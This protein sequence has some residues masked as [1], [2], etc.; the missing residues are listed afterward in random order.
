MCVAALRVRCSVELCFSTTPVHGGVASGWPTSRLSSNSPGQEW[1][2]AVRGGQCADR[3]ARL[4]TRKTVVSRC[5]H[6]L[7]V[8]AQSFRVR[9]AYVTTG[10][11]DV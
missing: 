6:G 2:A 8:V 9:R 5:A 10:R 7:V 4:S 1:A 11:V 3:T